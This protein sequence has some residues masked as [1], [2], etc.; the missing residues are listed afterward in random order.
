MIESFSCKETAKVFRSERSRKFPGEIQGRAKLRLM[1]IHQ[2]TELIQIAL[3]PS[4]QLHPLQGDL[5]GFWSV[6]INQ[7]WRV[8]FR[9]DDGRASQVKITDYH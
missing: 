8:T 6:R 5:A 2:A 4:N 1:Q 3:P 7:Q 9:W